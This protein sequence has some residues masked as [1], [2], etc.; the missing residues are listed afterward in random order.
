[1]K[2]SIVTLMLA[3]IVSAAFSQ[4]P[5]TTH[6]KEYEYFIMVSIK[7]YQQLT[8]IATAFVSQI[9]Y[10]PLVKADEKISAQINIERYLFDLPKSVKLDSTLK[11]NYAK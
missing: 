4:K 11:N 10:N 1:M 5:D 8:G 3:F 6:R 9:K 7:D 2:K